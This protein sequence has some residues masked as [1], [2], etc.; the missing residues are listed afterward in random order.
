[1]FLLGAIGYL[2]HI[3]PI[4]SHMWCDF[5]FVCGERMRCLNKS[6]GYKYEMLVTF[7]AIWYVFTE[8]C[9]PAWQKDLRDI[10]YFIFEAMEET[11]KKT[12]GKTTRA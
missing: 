4:F 12:G 2:Y 1:M 5:F 8:L 6:L 11:K 10:T 3:A 7:H 9:T